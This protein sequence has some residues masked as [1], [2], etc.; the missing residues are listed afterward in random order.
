M[1][2]KNHTIELKDTCTSEMAR[3]RQIMLSIWRQQIED[4]KNEIVMNQYIKLNN[5]TQPYGDSLILDQVED[6]LF[7][8]FV[9]VNGHFYNKDGTFEGKINTTKNK[10]SVNDVYVCDGKRN[11]KD[12]F[13]N[14]SKL[15]I[16]HENFC[17]I[18]GVIKSEDSSTF[19]SAAA[20]TQATFNA[21]KFEKG[22]KLTIEEQGKFAKKLL[23][24]G[25]STAK[26]KESLKDTE[27]DNLCKNARKGLI[28]VLQGKKD[29]SE[30]AVLWD[31]I[32]FADRGVI[33]D[34]PHPKT[35]N[36]GGIHITKELWVKFVNNSEYKPDSNGVLKLNR[37]T[38]PEGRL[39]DKTKEEVLAT[40]PFKKNKSEITPKNDY[41]DIFNF[42]PTEDTIWQSSNKKKD[43]DYYESL[44]TGRNSGRVLHKAT[45]V[46]GKH[47]FW[48]F[49]YDSP[50]NKGY[51]W[52]YYMNHKL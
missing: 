47:I 11:E 42:H 39:H 31:G 49:Y 28:H 43:I 41:Y 14:V 34:R 22:E 6:I 9:N 18:A 15:D 52:K 50:N 51:L 48:K 46:V 2:I 8:P 30:G 21:V 16:T 7:D 32:D 25:Y 23:S 17:Y 45:V 40:I 13:L 38:T 26:S 10:G 35:G 36:E 4:D 12:T 37:H 44:G 19:E 3:F 5:L 27:N 1:I 33:S 24:T 29:Y 20:T